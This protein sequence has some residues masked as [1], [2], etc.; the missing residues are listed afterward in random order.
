MGRKKVA[1][2]GAHADVVDGLDS[3]IFQ[4][5]AVGGR[6]VEEEPAAVIRQQETA[7]ELRGH[8]CADLIA[9]TADAWADPGANVA[10]LRPEFVLHSLEGNDC[11]SGP[12]SAPAGV[13]ETGSAIDRI[14]QNDRETVRMSREQ[15]DP[16][17]V[18]D[19]RVDAFDETGRPMHSRHVRPM[20]RPGDCERGVA[21][22]AKDARELH[23]RLQ[24]RLSV[25]R[26]RETHRTEQDG[27]E[28]VDEPGF[29]SELGNHERGRCR[30]H[31]MKITKTPSPRIAPFGHKWL[32]REARIAPFGHK[33]RYRAADACDYERRELR[34]CSIS[35][36]TCWR[37]MNSR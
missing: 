1:L 9:A 2:L 17:A 22:K 3:G 30:R 6:Q 28:A 33:W 34:T 24:H 14:P 19:Q 18:G 11:D 5:G 8:L 35:F 10:W 37:S 21:V 13:R 16:R 20:D 32:Y 27:G 23:P 26:V 25:E 12:R 36:L 7:L 4:L 29:V 15:S 31:A